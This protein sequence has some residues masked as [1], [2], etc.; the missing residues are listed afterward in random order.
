M[1][2]LLILL[3][4]LVFQLFMP[5]WIVA[6]VAFGLSIWKAHSGKHAFW[7]GFF[8]IFLLWL[9]AALFKSIPN[10]NL[11]AAKIATVFS[12]PHWILLLL[13]TCIIGGLTGGFSA[14]AGYFVKQAAGRSSVIKN[15]SNPV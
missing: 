14:L 15:H 9:V 13:V 2:L 6:I 4:A 1:L 5:F 8:A 3:I 7:S 10:E 12:L 11:L